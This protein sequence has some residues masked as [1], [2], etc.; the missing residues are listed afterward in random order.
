[1]IE[2]GGEPVLAPGEVVDADPTKFCAAAPL[3]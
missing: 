3:P 2:H 1:M